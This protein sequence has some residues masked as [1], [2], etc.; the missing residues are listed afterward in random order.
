MFGI[1]LK[2]LFLNEIIKEKVPFFTLQFQDEA[3]QVMLRDMLIAQGYEHDVATLIVVRTC[4]II[5]A[6]L[7]NHGLLM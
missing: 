5:Y 2:I 4:L 7:I 1:A 3:F 6:K